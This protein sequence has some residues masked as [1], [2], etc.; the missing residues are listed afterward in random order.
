MK[1]SLKHLSAQ[2]EE[3]FATS[4]NHVKAA[5]APIGLAYLVGRVD[6]ALRQLIGDAVQA[7]GLTV[8]QYTA[9]SVIRTRGL[10]S[11]AQLAKR[12]LISPQ[13]S[14]ELI[15]VM[16]S[17]GWIEREP[18]PTHGRIMLIRLTLVGEDLL[19]QSDR[20]V[21]RIEQLM[22][23]GIDTGHQQAFAQAL[24]SCLYALSPRSHEG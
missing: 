12:S 1:A 6:R 14:S 18:D 20:V 8:Q 9:L 11:N 13:A 4:S 2:K 19:T 22:L 5:Q 16:Q 21:A 24:K 10:L 15:K 23:S 7:Q 3:S 17:N